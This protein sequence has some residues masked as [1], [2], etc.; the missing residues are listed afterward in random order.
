MPGNVGTK[1]Y[2]QLIE[3]WIHHMSIYRCIISYLKVCKLKKKYYLSYLLFKNRSE[4]ILLFQKVSFYQVGD[5]PF[6]DTDVYVTYVLL[7][8]GYSV[9]VCVDCVCVFETFVLP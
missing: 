1:Q 4:N 6:L 9:C 5:Q 8:G 3:Y 7:G 2:T